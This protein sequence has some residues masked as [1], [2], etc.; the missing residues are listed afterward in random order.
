MFINQTLVFL[1]IIASHNAYTAI[2]GY[3][4]IIKG[5]QIRKALNYR[6]EAYQVFATDA[7]GTA[8]PIPFQ[9]DEVNNLGDYVLDQGNKP[10]SASSNGV[11]DF[12][13]ELTIMGNDVGA[14]TMP[15]KF[16]GGPPDTLYQVDI[17][18]PEKKLKGSI[19]IG[20]FYK[21]LPKKTKQKYVIFDEN[22]HSIKTSSYQYRFDPKNY[23]VVS[24]IEKVGLSGLPNRKIIDSST[25]YMQA[26]L[27]Y[28]LTV[29]ANHRS[30]NSYLESYKSGPIRT[31][32]RINFYYTFLKLNFEVGMYTEI[33]FF[34]N[35][36]KLPAIIYSPING[37][38]TLNSKSYFYYGFAFSESLDDY[39]ITTNIPEWGRGFQLFNQILDI[40][41]KEKTK[42]Y[43]ASLIGNDHQ[44][45]LELKPSKN[46][47]QL[48]VKPELYK[49]SI[50]GGSLVQNRNNNEV[51]AIEEAPI[52]IAVGFNLTKFPEGESK[53]SF[54]L[55]FENKV[56]P[57]SI[58]TYKTLDNWQYKVTRLK[59]TKVLSNE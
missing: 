17:S 20:I 8:H 49:N 51:L 7:Q 40:A 22:G 55:F 4:V 12:Y 27:K 31:I 5:Y 28:F 6:T 42:S 38:K 57:T 35:A 46:L 43:W 29:R 9:I 2:H 11:F 30:V 41:K 32:I 48:G 34:T 3:P 56:D 19:F 10:N 47:T 24:E 36:V 13:D 44:V 45:Y 1:A 18:L 39:N 21:D 15:K 53:M 26:D 33:S 52:N 54:N 14:N 25:F 50:E 23:L 16:M 58:S 37:N 59:V